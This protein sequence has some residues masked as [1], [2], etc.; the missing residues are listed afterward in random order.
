MPEIA[1][2]MPVH[3]AGC[4]VATAVASLQ[5]Q[6]FR[7]FVLFACD[8]GSTGYFAGDGAERHP[9]QVVAESSQS[10]GDRYVEPFMEGGG[11]GF[12]I[13]RPHGR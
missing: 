13:L 6:S 4:F 9:D 10:G 12:P 3:N 8:D 1:V 7:D 11:A 2:L 5:R